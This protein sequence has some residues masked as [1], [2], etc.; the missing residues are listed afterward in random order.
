ML[1]NCNIKL[2]CYRCR[3]YIT[4]MLANCNIKLPCYRL[5]GFCIRILLGSPQK[6]LRIGSP[7][8]YQGPLRQWS[9]TGLGNAWHTRWQLMGGF[10][11][12]HTGCAECVIA[13]PGS[14]FAC[15]DHSTSVASLELV[16]GAEQPEP[17]GGGAEGRG[18]VRLPGLHPQPAHRHPFPPG[19]SRY[20]FS[21]SDVAFDSMGWSFKPQGTVERNCRPLVFL[22]L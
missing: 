2:P 12:T 8:W 17:G 16:A 14:G 21:I 22:F 5:F 18:R 9:G 6:K 11:A 1:A 20:I 19:H 10:F 15:L 7:R 3:K 4:I 13:F